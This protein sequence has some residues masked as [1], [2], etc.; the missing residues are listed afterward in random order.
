[1]NP[2]PM[3]PL[4]RAASV[5]SLAKDARSARVIAKTV[6]Q[7]TL[8]LSWPQMEASIDESMRHA[9]P[10]TLEQLRDLLEELRQRPLL[11]EKRPGIFYVESPSSTFTTIL[12]EFL[13]M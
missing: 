13:L 6:G 7:A 9:G 5:P 11:N 4:T 1:M 2:P 10:D 8:S 3:Q 12:L